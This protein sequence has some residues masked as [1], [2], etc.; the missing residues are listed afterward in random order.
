MKNILN[1]MKAVLAC[2]FVSL[3]FVACSDDDDL[4]SADLGLGIK[5][6]APT[7]VV[8]GQP[9][10]INGSGFDD[11]AEIEFPGGVKVSSFELVTNEMIRLKAP[12]GM[13][14]EGGKVILHG[15]DGK[16]VES[17]QS[18]TIGKTVVSGY[19]LQPGEKIKGL[20]ELTIYGEDL[21]FVNEIILLDENEEP[22]TV[23]QTDFS[24]L[25]PNRLILKVPN[26]IFTG[27]FAGTIKTFD[28]QSFTMPEFEYEPTQQGGHWETVKTYLWKNGE[29][30]TIPA[31]SW[32][33][34]GRFSNVSHI[35]GE[36][37]YAFSEEEWELLRTQPFRIE[38][39]K[40][41]YWVN[42]RVTTGWWSTNYLGMESLN[43]LVEQ[44][45]DGNYFV[46][47]DL[48]KD[49]ALLAVLDE[50]HLLFTG[51]DYKLLGIYVLEQKWVGG[52]GHMEIV[53]TSFWKN[54]EQSTIPAPS[55]SG[56]GRFSSV[57]HITGE[58]TYAFSEEE[59]EIL[60]T[61]P[62]RIAIEKNADWVNLRVTTGWWSTNYLGMESLNDL[63]QQD[64]DGTYYVELD[65]SK[66]AALLAVLDEQHLLFTGQ[67]Y[68]LLEIYQVKEEWVGGNGAVESELNINGDCVAQGDRSVAW[69]FP[70]KMT[71]DDNGRFRI[72]RDGISNLKD[73][74]F[75]ADETVM[76]FYKTGTGQIQ[77]NNP[78]WQSFTSVSD[79]EGSLE[80]LELVL[81]QDIID[82]FTGVTS[83]GWS[84]TALILQGD[85]LTVSKIT[86]E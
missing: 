5:V 15:K 49:A 54:G 24:R 3:A 20:E 69:T 59:W 19:S 70:T 27:V 1:Y 83:D 39:E 16:S 31:P 60:K 81:T 29:H 25:A 10:T 47:L 18:I 40:L 77:V 82:C 38:I 67:D 64:E 51:Q 11:L 61:Q 72:M 50:Q 52:E 75:K 78:N 53:K 13:P 32:S 57:S 41:A 21:L 68:K 12:A 76:R 17:R 71:W 56:E 66:D 8:A 2:L 85:G 43:D 73:F 34:E 33:G 9:M 23:P 45:E 30:S 79:W 37:T 74:K 26:N 42:L 80:V 14:A 65:L 28:G 48:S 36:Q 62:F 35:T 4:G 44:D 84:E 7:H 58:Q 55:W 6:F 86:I 46:E 63:I 22:L